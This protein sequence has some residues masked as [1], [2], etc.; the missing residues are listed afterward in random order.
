M[1]NIAFISNTN[2]VIVTQLY[3]IFSDDIYA[4]NKFIKSV[5]T[6][7][8]IFLNKWNVTEYAHK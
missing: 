4:H 7:F 1:K 3:C 5:R 8:L 6:L 2:I